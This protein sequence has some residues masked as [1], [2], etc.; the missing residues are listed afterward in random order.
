MY[1]VTSRRY[2]IIIKYSIQKRDN[3]QNEPSHDGVFIQKYNT[4]RNNNCMKN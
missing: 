4:N 2:K 3:E 1:Y